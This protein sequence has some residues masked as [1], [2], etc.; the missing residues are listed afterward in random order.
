MF[1][2]LSS[3]YQLRSSECLWGWNEDSVLPLALE[4]RKSYWIGMG[5]VSFVIHFVPLMWDTWS[6]GWHF[7]FPCVVFWF[8]Y[9]WLVNDLCP[10]FCPQYQSFWV[11]QLQIVVTFV[12][13]FSQYQGLQPQLQFNTTSVKMLVYGIFSVE[14]NV[15]GSIGIFHCG[16][17]CSHII[18]ILKLFF[19]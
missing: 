13:N 4:F 5:S 7:G 8:W 12:H 15:N 10:R 17:Q 14:T 3:F 9:N 11:T 2:F 6:A 18:H 1:F 19:L 16:N